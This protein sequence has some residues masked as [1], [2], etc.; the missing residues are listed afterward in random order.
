MSRFGDDFSG[1]AKERS[2]WLIPLAVLVVTAVLSAIVLAYYFGPTPPELVQE[3]QAPSEATSRVG[4]RIG[5]LKLRIPANYLPFESAREGG[6]RGEIVLVA[7]LPDLHGYSASEASEFAS[8]AP[9]SDSVHLLIRQEANALSEKD[10]LQR[11]YLAQVLKREGVAGPHGLRKYTFR[12][13]TGYRADD[14]FVGQTDHG[15]VVLRCTHTSEIA[16]SPNCLRQVLLAPGITLSYRF[17][18]AH[19]AQWRA[20]DY[21]VNRLIDSFMRKPR[22][23]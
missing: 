17:K 9:N 14:L 16:K 7:L 3:Q 8:N 2:G 22:V 1:R 6:A 20:I 5:T 15:A 10:R 12:P 11:I 18:R 13:E 21:G 23:R 19:L 4:L